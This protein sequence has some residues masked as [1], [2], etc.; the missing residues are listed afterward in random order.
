MT[1]KLMKT[2]VNSLEEKT[3]EDIPKLSNYEGVLNLA[4]HLPAL[5]IPVSAVLK[6][7]LLYNQNPCD[8]VV[9]KG[10]GG[11]AMALAGLAIAAGGTFL[12][13][14]N[15]VNEL[16]TICENTQRKDKEVM[17]ETGMYEDT[18]HP[19]YFTQ[20]LMATGFALMSPALD[21][22][23]ALAI[24]LGLTQKCAKTEEKVCLAKFG[25][26]YRKYM[27]KV[28]R[29]PKLSSLKTLFD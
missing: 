10:P 24:Y 17:V 1:L 25:K 14:E 29:W 22:A 13:M 11:I 8:Y 20:T 7:I 16:E 4:R 18:R 2:M 15:D 27:D 5:Y 6:P 21:T 3:K 12:K 23:G 28:P 26:K 19:C 9:D